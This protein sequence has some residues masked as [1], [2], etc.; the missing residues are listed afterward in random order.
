M[1]A[2]DH[3]IQKQMQILL[4]ENNALKSD[5]QTLLNENRDL[6]SERDMICNLIICILAIAGG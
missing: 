2:T 6:K 1:I 3:K 5:K 4:S